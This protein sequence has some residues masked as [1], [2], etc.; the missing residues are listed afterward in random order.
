MSNSDVVNGLGV[1]R[2]KAGKETVKRT[3]SI[4]GDKQIGLLSDASAVSGP[5]HL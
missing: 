5:L 1:E 2:G 4:E 3:A